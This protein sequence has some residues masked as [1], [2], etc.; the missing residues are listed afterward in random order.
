MYLFDFLDLWIVIFHVILRDNLRKNLTPSVI[1]N[2]VKP[3]PMAVV[4]T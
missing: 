4:E 1:T 2:D 3:L